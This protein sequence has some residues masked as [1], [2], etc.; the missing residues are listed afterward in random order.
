MVHTDTCFILMLLFIPIKVKTYRYVNVDKLNRIYIFGGYTISTDH[1]CIWYIDL[2]SA[3][4]PALDC[5]N[6]TQ[7][8]YPHPTDCS[9]F[10]TC[11][12]RAGL[13]PHPSYCTK[14]IVC[15]QGQA[16]SN[17]NDCPEPLLFDPVLLKCNLSQYVDAHNFRG[18]F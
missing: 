6:L 1:D 11:E 16:Q 18:R 8:S 17:V 2:P 4:I 15:R 14:F 13:H 10:F 3:P 5:S 9:S 12:G 7:G